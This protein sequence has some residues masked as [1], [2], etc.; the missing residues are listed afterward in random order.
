M[1]G[2]THVL[3]WHVQRAATMRMGANPQNMSQ[4]GLE[5]VTR[6]YEVGFASNRASAMAR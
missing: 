6:L 2:A 5:S 4:F 1:F 3:Q